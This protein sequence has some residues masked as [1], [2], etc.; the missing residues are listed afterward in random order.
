MAGGI[1]IQNP[2]LERPVDRAKLIQTSELETGWIPS[3]VGVPTYAAREER[4][5]R[6][7][8]PHP[9]LHT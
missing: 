3:A 5:G 4:M 9:S 8:A 1:G 2:N 6:A 7:N